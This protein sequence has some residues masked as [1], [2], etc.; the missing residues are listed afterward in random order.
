MHDIR[1]ERSTAGVAKRLARHK[2]DVYRANGKRQTSCTKR[3]GRPQPPCPFCPGIRALCNRSR[4]WQVTPR[5]PHLVTYYLLLL[6]LP[7]RLVNP[8]GHHQ[9][10]ASPARLSESRA[11]PMLGVTKLACSR[12]NVTQKEAPSRLRISE[13]ACFWPQNGPVRK[14]PMFFSAPS[15]AVSTHCFPFFFSPLSIQAM[16]KRAL[17]PHNQIYTRSSMSHLFVRVA[18]GLFFFPLCN[19]V[20]CSFLIP[21][22]PMCGH[23][24]NG[25]G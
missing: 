18:Q 4:P 16:G 25:P 2:S 10:A 20:L 6:L 1:G 19:F 11:R 13:D 22:L 24:R 15:A 21:A 23:A 14:L 3:R 12:P 5:T 7:P 17:K 8:R 9:P